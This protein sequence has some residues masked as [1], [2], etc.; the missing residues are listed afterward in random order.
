VLGTT[1]A[2]KQLMYNYI[3]TTPWQIQGINK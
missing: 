2:P 1:I 3:T